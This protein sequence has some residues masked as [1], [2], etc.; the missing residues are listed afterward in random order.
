M[1]ALSQVTGGIDAE[2]L[3]PPSNSLR[4]VVWVQDAAFGGGSDKIGL[5]ST[6]IPTPAM[7]L[8]QLL[9]PSARIS[10]PDEDCPRKVA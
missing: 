7:V 9:Y 2:T 5:F 10:L 6:C 8:V 1:Q 4:Y 3:I